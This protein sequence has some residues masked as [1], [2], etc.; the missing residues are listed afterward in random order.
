MD[1]YNCF[2]LA[3]IKNIRD[4]S[5]EAEYVWVIYLKSADCEFTQLIRFDEFHLTEG[6]F[7]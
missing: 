1:I 2:M 4:L 7:T 3:E 5:Y 6:S